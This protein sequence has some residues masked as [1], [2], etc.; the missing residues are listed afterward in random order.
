MITCASKTYSTAE[1]R[2]S[3]IEKEALGIVFGFNRFQQFLAGR[4][5]LLYTE[6]KQHT[7]IVKP[8]A[9]I[10]TTALQRIQR[11]SM[12]F[13]KFSYNVHHRLCNSNFQADA[14][15]R[16]P[17]PQV[18]GLDANISAV[19]QEFIERGPVNAVQVLKLL[20]AI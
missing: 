20:G 6:H 3:Q 4:Q 8:A 14:L 13:A 15:S 2:Y 10:S 1:R 17:P 12:Y 11:W 18:G 9:E 7:F 5:V 19:K 16:S